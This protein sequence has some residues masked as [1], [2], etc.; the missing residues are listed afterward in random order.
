MSM[1]NNSVFEKKDIPSELRQY[2]EEIAVQ[3]G[4]QW[5][6]V[7]EKGELVPTSERG[8]H[9]WKSKAVDDGYNYDARWEGKPGKAFKS[10]TIGWRPTCKCGKDPV[11]CTVFD[12]FMGAGTV[13]LVAYNL[14][15]NYAGCEIS[16]EYIE[17]AEERIGSEKEKFLL[18]EKGQKV[19]F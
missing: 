17:M 3:C 4:A 16:P 12:P 11:P 8:K 13:G 1:M 6:R 9:E 19:L 5:A 14:N 2:F 7:V 10:T 15:R 18:L